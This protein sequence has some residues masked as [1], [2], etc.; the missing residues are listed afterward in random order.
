MKKKYT[1]ADLNTDHDFI[2]RHIGPRPKQQKEMLKFIGFDS[3]DS[4]IDAIIPKNIL[5]RNTMELPEPLS[6]ISM[7]DHMHKISHKNKRV[8]TFI[9][10]GYY[11][12]NTP[13]VI[14][15]NVL[16]NPGW[17]TAY[18][19]YQAEISQGR[20]EAIINF[21]T[22]VSDLTGLDISNASLLDE[23]T[24]V[25]EAMNMCSNVAKNKKA[26]RFFLSCHLHPQTIDVVRGR[27]EHFEIEII[28]G[29]EDDGLPD[30]LMG[31]AFQYPRTTGALVDYSNHIEKL[32]AMGALAIVAADLLALT[33]VKTPADMGAD[34]AVGSAQRFGVPFNFGGPHAGYIATKI[35]LQRAIPGRIIGVSIDKHGN[36]AYRMAM[37][38]REQH[39]R[40]ERATSNICT[41]QA[42]LA[43]MAGFYGVYYGPIGLRKIAHRTNILTRALKLGLN[44]IGFEV[45]SEEF[46]DTIAFKTENRAKSY[47]QKALDAGYNICLID[48]NMVS[49][50]FDGTTDDKDVKNLLEAFGMKNVDLEKLTD[51][52]KESIVPEMVRTSKFMQHP[53]FNEKHSETELMRY[54]RYLV[55]K[56]IAL[57][58][59]MIPLGSCT[60]KLNAATQMTPLTFP[61][62][63]T[64][65]PFAPIDQTAGYRTLIETLEE[66]LCIITG[67][68]AISVQPNAGSQGEYAGLIAIKKYYK[69]KGETN[70]NVCLIP[71]SAH[72][73]NPAS[74]HMANMKVVTVACLKDGNIDT[75]DLKEKC[76]AHKDNLAVI[77]ITY[78]STH[79]VFEDNVKEVCKLVHQAGGQVYIDGANMNAQIGLSFPGHYGGDV[80]HLNLHKTF[81]IPHGGG[82]PGVGPIGVKSHLAPFLPGHSLVDNARGKDG[83]VTSAPWGSASVLTITYAYIAMLGSTG[84]TKATENAILSANYIARKL[85]PYYPVLYKGKTGYVAHE[86]IFDI[87][88]LE[89]KSGISNEDISKRL[90][91]YGFHA[92]TMSFP[93]PGTLMVEPTESESLQELDRFIAAMVS[94][95]EEIDEVMN[96]KADRED[97]VLKN[98]PHTAEEALIGE[99]KHSYTRQKAIY[100]VPALVQN[101]IWPTVGRIDNVYGDRNLFCS[102]IPMDKYKSD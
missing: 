9:G 5:E 62:F 42:L 87:R 67:Y 4:M 28:E 11:G 23:G 75:S 85:E 19:P 78:P 14:V 80:S 22:I 49:I 102:C 93:V 1:L 96:G 94:I 18:T 3:F 69:S 13:Q 36:P 8:K 7:I 26:N 66:R 86:C 77:M 99:W 54:S 58:R 63:S 35:K 21:Q 20:L 64:I 91:D 39:V 101:K 6:E 17:Y 92:P 89:E 57:D 73:T 47:T 40:R 24:A 55:N 45:V 82:G 52:A 37:Q 79:G 70:R 27:A 90:M 81:A 12:N 33:I 31:A 30:N 10:R 61:G 60:M 29:D 25:A 41:A 16:E 68:D 43:I 46:F 97:N 100:P 38:T 48:D 88:G 2:F 56:D 53:I 15:R 44:K 83:A 95:R 59:A 74:A 76:T 50:S 34:I 71:V 98:S 51:E 65:H 84:L 72:G 32:H